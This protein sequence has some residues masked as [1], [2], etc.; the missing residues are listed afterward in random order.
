MEGA[1][2]KWNRKTRTFMWFMK[3][4]LNIKAN[5]HP[6]LK[7]MWPLGQKPVV[8]AVSVG[9]GSG[10]HLSKLGE[11]VGRTR[12]TTDCP[13][14]DGLMLVETAKHLLSTWLEAKEQDICLYGRI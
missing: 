6:I 11:N 5:P 4:N 13:G 3:E 9:T 2:I 8:N 14:G 1:N 7:D 12:H 10:E